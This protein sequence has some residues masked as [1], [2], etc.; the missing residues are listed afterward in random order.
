M[1]HKVSALIG[2]YNP[3]TADFGVGVSGLHPMVLGV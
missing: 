2:G 3:N 1:R